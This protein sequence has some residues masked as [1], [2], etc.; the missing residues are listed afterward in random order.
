MV[1]PP[2]DSDLDFEYYL[3]VNESKRM[4]KELSFLAVET[5][6]KVYEIPLQDL[7]DLLSMNLKEIEKEVASYPKMFEMKEA[8][9]S[10]AS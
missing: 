2:K 5:F 6:A 9:L 1:Q 4:Y 8:I 7:F 3:P 10:K